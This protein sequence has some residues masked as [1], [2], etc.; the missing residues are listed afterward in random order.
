VARTPSSSWPTPTSA[1]A[2][3]VAVKARFIKAGQS[4]VNAKRFIVEASVAD[5]FVATFA[6]DVA[7]LRLGDPLLPGTAIGPLARANLRVV[8]HDQV[9]RTVA[10][11]ALLLCGGQ[12]PDGPGFFYPLTILDHVVPGMAAFEEETFGPV[13]AVVR[14][15]DPD[16]AIALAN[17]TEFGLAA[18][19]WTRDV[20]YAQYLSRRI[21]AGAVFVNGLVASDPRL[22]FGGIKRSGY[23]RELGD[24]GIREF[25]NVKTLWVGTASVAAPQGAVR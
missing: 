4:C 18:A 22:P 23:G 12:L 7:P 8:L 21:Q 2:A 6:D 9:E 16:A 24:V 10:A 13:A 3:E 20:E 17:Q 19:L 5:A 1:G 25:V 11:G 14:A 15:A